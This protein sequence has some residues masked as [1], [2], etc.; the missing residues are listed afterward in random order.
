M[1]FCGEGDEEGDVVGLN[2]GFVCG[3]IAAEGAASGAAVGDDKAAARVGFGESGLHLPAAVGGTVAGIFVEMEG[4]E[5]EGAVIAGGI[6]EGEH[7]APAV[8]AHKAAVV[9]RKPS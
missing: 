2:F 9:F 6:A 5:A 8:G 4:P 1:F 7:L 3:F